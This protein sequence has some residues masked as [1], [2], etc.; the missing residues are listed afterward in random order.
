MLSSLFAS[1]HILV[2]IHVQQMF[3]NMALWSMVVLCN[4]GCFRRGP[5]V[6]ILHVSVALCPYWIVSVWIVYWCGRTVI[7]LWSSGRHYVDKLAAMSV[8]LYA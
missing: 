8:M 5:C 4:C 1:T 2:E 7:S 3:P 6:S